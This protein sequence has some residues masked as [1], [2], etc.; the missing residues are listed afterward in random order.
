M[1]AVTTVAL[2]ALFLG[3]G[4]AQGASPEGSPAAQPAALGLTV[5]SDGMLIRE[6]R[7]Y[8]GI[9]VNYFDAFARHLA[10]PHNTS[11]DAGFAALAKAQISFARI[12]G[13]GFWPKEQRLYQ[14]DPREFFRR[15]DDVVRCA[16]KHKIGLIPSLFW[17]DFTVPDL[18]GESLDQWGNPASKTRAYMRTYVR[19]VVTRYRTSPAIWGWELGNEY[20]LAADLPNAAQH[21]P[22]VVPQL[23]TANSRTAKDELTYAVVRAAFVAF[24]EEVRKYD[25]SRVISTGNSRPRESAWHNWKEKSWKTDTPEQQARMLRDDNPDPVDLVSVHLYDVPT[26]YVDAMAGIARRLHKPLFVGEFG[27]GSAHGAA[28]ECERFQTLLAAIEHAKVPLA[29]LWVYDY[30]WQ[31]RTFNITWSNARSYQLKAIAEANARI[32]KALAE[33]TE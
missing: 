28:S 16:E 10:D 26:G 20:N 8:R 6:G 14:E 29:A 23:G 17:A 22:P 27:A 30:Q 33:E 13:C 18:V 31:D 32:R 19:D 2:L 21:R 9:G 15:F 5:R 7:P 24:A 3:A 1:I 11:Y 25:D 12:E 4:L